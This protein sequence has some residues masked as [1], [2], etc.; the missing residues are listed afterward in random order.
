MGVRHY[1][2]WFRPV[3]QRSLT[4]RL[5][6][7]PLPRPVRLTL[8]RQTGLLQRPLTMEH[9]TTID[10]AT[11]ISLAMQICPSNIGNTELYLKYAVAYNLEQF[12]IFDTGCIAV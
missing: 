4:G 5:P 1:P 10:D 6:L 9:L 3:R 12:Q 7:P 11:S 2:T 8:N